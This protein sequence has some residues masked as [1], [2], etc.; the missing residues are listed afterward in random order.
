MILVRRSDFHWLGA[1]NFFSFVQKSTLS[2]WGMAQKV[3]KIFIPPS[4]WR[5]LLFAAR[6]S[7]MYETVAPH[8]GRDLA[9]DAYYNWCALFGCCPR[10]SI[11][12]TLSHLVNHKVFK[13]L[14]SHFMDGSRKTKEMKFVVVFR[15][16][17]NKQFHF[18]WKAKWIYSWNLI[19]V[20]LP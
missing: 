12:R 9:S 6:L 11:E 16:K 5:H 17:S 2:H 15:F 8:E 19:L 4:L 1:T 7:H 14:L 18:H 10:G 13:N 20:Y 3:F